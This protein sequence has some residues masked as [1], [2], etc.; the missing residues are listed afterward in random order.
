MAQAHG[1]S[2]C[3]SKKHKATRDRESLVH[4]LCHVRSGSKR[5]G[6]NNTWLNIADNAGTTK[7]LPATMVQKA[8]AKPRLPLGSRLVYQQWPTS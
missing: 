5:A 1:K 7:I 4:I 2:N 3:T 8:K 6:N